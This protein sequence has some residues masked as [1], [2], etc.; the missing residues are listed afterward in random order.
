MKELEQIILPNIFEDSSLLSSKVLE[1]GTLEI[2]ALDGLLDEEVTV[3][4]IQG[5]YNTLK[6]TREYSVD[7]VITNEATDGLGDESGLFDEIP[8]S[9]RTIENELL[10]VVDSIAADIEVYIENL[11]SYPETIREAVAEKPPKFKYY[12]FTKER[13]VDGHVLWVCNEIT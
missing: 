9:E 6:N 11:K 8:D 12:K 10:T 3:A 2:Y 13:G 4:T 1:D 7:V 5:Y